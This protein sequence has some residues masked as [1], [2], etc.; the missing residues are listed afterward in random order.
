MLF[1]YSTGAEALGE[2]GRKGVKR[3]LRTK[4]ETAILEQLRACRNED[5]SFIDNPLIGVDV[6]TGLALSCML[7][8]ME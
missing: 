2:L 3:R 7:D 4:V 5:G 1:D 8:L 6:A